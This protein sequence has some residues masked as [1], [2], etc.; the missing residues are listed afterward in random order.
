MV[1]LTFNGTER[2]KSAVECKISAYVPI[3]PEMLLQSAPN[4]PE[5]VCSISRNAA[6][7]PA[8]TVSRRNRADR[9][10]PNRSRRTGEACHGQPVPDFSRLSG[11]GSVQPVHSSPICH[12]RDRLSAV[13]CE[14]FSRIAP[15]YCYVQLLKQEKPRI[16]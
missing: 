15:N 8:R 6:E 5:T 3:Y 13:F 12:A 2:R 10:S 11:R 7:D 1:H 16:C 14:F 4:Q 9:I